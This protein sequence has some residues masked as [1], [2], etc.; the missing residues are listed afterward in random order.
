LSDFADMKLWFFC[1]LLCFS[2]ICRGQENADSKSDT[3]AVLQLLEK[4][5]TYNFSKADTGLKLAE[6]ALDL[7]RK[8]NFKK[9]EALSLHICGE[10][11]N[12]LGDYPRS[13][14]REFEAVGIF[15]KIGDES[16]EAD[17]LSYIG[18][19]NIQLGQYREA[20]G[21][22]MSIKEID[23]QKPGIWNDPFILANIGDV[24][25]SIK[26]PDSALY[27]Q[28]Q[29]YK[30]FPAILRPHLR[31]FILRHMGNIYAQFGKNDSAVKYYRAAISNARL[32]N[33]NINLSSAS[34][35][36][37]EAYK[38]SR[39][40][41]SSLY[42]AK[43]SYLSA[44]NANATLQLLNASTLLS[45]LYRNA[46][47]YDSALF[48]ADVAA[49]SKN[50]LFGPEKY[51]QMQ[52][53]LLRQ[54]Q[55]EEGVREEGEEFKNRIKYIALSTALGIFL[56]LAFILIRNN[57]QKQKANELLKNQKSIVE[58]SLA[59]LK[60]T[61]AQL[62]QREKMASLGELTT[63]IA[64]EIQNPLNFINNFS[65]LNKE[66]LDE[67]TEAK[68]SGQDTEAGELL[69]TLKENQEKIYHHGKR[70]D[71]IVKGMLQHSR[72]SKGVKEP[73]DINILTDE[74]LRLAFNGFRIKQDSID[75]SIKT[76]YDKTIGR[77]NIIPGDIG[78]VLLNIFNNAFYAV[79]EKKKHAQAEFEPEVFVGSKKINGQIEIKIRDNGTG[80]PSTSV[81]KIFQP[82]YT[83]KPTGEG[84]GLGLSISYDIVKAHEGE[85]KVSSSEGKFTE[86]TIQL[87]GA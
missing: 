15:K 82:F 40:Y 72:A 17:A 29:A 14:Q 83:T 57:R 43:E 56:L 47:L 32:S 36:M 37:A 67:L 11:Y 20:L 5:N 85:L 19:L 41:D 2:A 63:G 6:Q 58:K 65:E 70:A 21:Y 78:R 62:V 31:S 34:K 84:T 8:I 74:Y 44:R 68:N 26:M 50:S 22:F 86:F 39:Q 18:I 13:L 55:Q 80:V 54:Q 73:T 52:L 35:E 42:Y 81:D 66:L 30:L 27:Y 61:Q 3:T 33:D 1:L 24:Y 9:G 38:S 75:I 77:I 12:M 16:G 51:R 49:S 4:A 48:Y 79:T 10:A 23:R 45:T 60:S 46:G 28:K 71:A 53:L 69:A 76:D 64:H 25:D 7:S 59:E 87:P